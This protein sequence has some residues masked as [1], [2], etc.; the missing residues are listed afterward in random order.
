MRDPRETV[1]PGEVDTLFP[2]WQERLGRALVDAPRPALLVAAMVALVLGLASGIAAASGKTSWSATTVVMID[3]PYGI[4]TA[5][6]E[7]VLVKLEQ[8]RS[9][10][11]GLLQTDL[12]AQPIASHLN[13]PVDKVRFA[14]APGVPPASLLMEVNATWSNPSTAKALSAAATDQLIHYVQSEQATYSIPA[15]DRFTLRVVDPTS[16]GTALR[17]SR[18][19]AV[20]VGIGFALLAFCVAFVVTQMFRNRRL[21]S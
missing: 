3:D 2:R 14:L 19:R 18:Y 8:L 7:G 21:L 1:W 13:L 20:T 6:D 15:A 10:Y 17:P 11:G 4:A 9:K 16:P 5:G 12:I